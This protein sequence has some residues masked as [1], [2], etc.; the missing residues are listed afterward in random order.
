MMHKCDNAKLNF[1]TLQ[2]L[3]AWKITCWMKIEGLA[4]EK[5]KKLKKKLSCKQLQIDHNLF[6]R[7]QIF[8]SK[9]YW[10][11]ELY[12][13]FRSMNVGKNLDAIVLWSI[14]FCQIFMRKISTILTST[15]WDQNV[16]L[17]LFHRVVSQ[18]DHCIIVTMVHFF[19]KKELNESVLGWP[20]GRIG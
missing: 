8:N 13:G 12:L 1:L 7:L 10:L 19:R 4:T 18:S 5:M 16:I 11:Y 17:S 3:N 20:L 14:H 2:L 9:Y 15:R 6:V